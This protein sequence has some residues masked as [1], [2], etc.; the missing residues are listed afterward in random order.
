VLVCAALIAVIVGVGRRANRRG[1]AASITRRVAA[2]GIFFWLV[3]Q[4]FA[5]GFDWKPAYSWPLHVCDLAGILGPI[6]LLTRIRLLR[7]TVYFWTMGLAVWGVVTPT[8]WKGPDTLTFWLFWINHGGVMLFAIYDVAV[9][10]YRPT[11]G[12]WGWACMVSLAY[13]AVVVPLNLAHPGWNYGY[14]GDVAVGRKTPLDWLPAW[15]WRL[16][17]IEV[18]G[19]LMM[20]LAWLPWGVLAWR[21]RR[22]ELQLMK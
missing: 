16:L 9:R 17:A 10:G 13:V 6:A 1:G 12:D 2:A 11:F 4:V 19:A 3:Q 21:K 14:L 8:L 5:F 18:L 22:R 20:L 7:T 15:P